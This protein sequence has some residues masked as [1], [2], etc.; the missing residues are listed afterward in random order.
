[1]NKIIPKIIV[2]FK[3]SGP[4]PVTVVRVS[5]QEPPLER[6]PEW[7]EFLTQIGFT[8]E[9]FCTLDMKWKDAFYKEFRRWLA[10]RGSS[11]GS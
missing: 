3:P 7:K 2:N 8:H 4:S 10:K 1:M 11:V 6:R 5:E 9:K